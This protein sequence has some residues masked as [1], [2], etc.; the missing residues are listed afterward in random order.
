MNRQIIFLT[1]ILSTLNVNAYDERSSVTTVE[2][3]YTSTN[4]ARPYVQFGSGSMPGCYAN[5]GGY[6]M[7]TNEQGMDRVFSMLLAAH[8]SKKPVSVYYNFSDVEE[9]YN[10]WSLCNIESIDLR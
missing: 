9:G 8:L 7:N 3:I 1:L 5:S 10:G 2:Y 6:L 4:G